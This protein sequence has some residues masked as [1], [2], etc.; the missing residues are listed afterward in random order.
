MQDREL[1][2][3][4]QIVSKP[5]LSP[6]LRQKAWDYSVAAN[7][8]SLAEENTNNATMVL[9]YT[10][11]YLQE[12]LKQATA[13]ESLAKDSFVRAL[14]DKQSSKMQPSGGRG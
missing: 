14:K 9:G 13:D 7:R 12:F 11:R 1:T 6:I 4:D 5:W 2:H 3:A 8:R 10:P